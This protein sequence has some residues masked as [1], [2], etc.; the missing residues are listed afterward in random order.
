MNDL[1][2]GTVTLLFAD[3]EGSTRLLQNLGEHYANLLADF[4]HLLRTAFAQHNG[5]E[6][7]TG[8]D[9]FFVAF[10]RASDAVAAAVDIQRTLANHSWPEG[11][12]VRVRI[13][14][15]TGEPQLSSEDYI[16]LE[17][18]HT[19]RIMSAGHGGQILLS[20]TT[21]E[22]VEQHLPV[23]TYLRDM[24]EHRLK[25]L[26]RPSHLFQLSITG[27]PEDFPPLK[28][29]D[30][31][32]NNLPIEPTTFI[33]RQKEIRALCDLLRRPDIRLLALTGPGGVGK[34]RLALRVAA[35][36]TELFRDGVFVV[37]LAPVYDPGQVVPAIAQ[38]LS[39][40]EA[41]DQPLF[42]LV[43]NVLREKRLLLLLDNFE[44][45]VDAAPQI[46]ELLSACPELK[47]LVTSRV[48]LH[49]Q[50]EREFA[51][52]PLPVP[53]PKRLPDPAALSQYEA[54]ALFIERATAVKPG[55]QVTNTNAPA[56]AAICARLDGLPLAIE[57]AAARIRH[58]SP[59]AL[60]ARLEQ[61]LAVL[62]GGA[63]DL[64]GR[65]QTL[66][67]AIAWSYELLS[68]DEQ[69]LFRRLSIFVDGCSWEATEEVC[70]AAGALEGD[71]LEGLVSLVDKSLLRLEE[72]TEGEARFWMLQ[73]LR[74]FGLECLADAG[75]WEVTRSAHALFYLRLAEEAE[76]H[77]R[78]PDAGRWFARLE[79]EHENLRAALSFLLEQAETGAGGEKNRW[80]EQVMRLCG[81][82]YWFWTIHGYYREGRSF[83]ERA[84]AVREGVAAPA[85]IK[86]L[87]AA[88][89]LAITQDDFKRAE[90]LC[91]ESL[92]LSQ[93]MGDSAH[94]ATA[95][96]QLGF[97]SLWR[98]QYAEA[99][100]HMEEAVSLFR[101]L[102]DTWN[103]ARALAYLA[104]V[105]AAQG[106]YSRA[107]LLGEES[108][109]LSRALGNKGRIAI[110]LSELARMSFLS[111]DDPDQAQ[112]LAEESLALFRELGDT[113]YIAVLY[114]LLGE[115]H[116]VQGQ[117]AEARELL[118]ES[119]ATFKE[120]GDRWS[121]AEALLS[122]ARIA[123]SLG[124]I[125]TAAASF[126]ESLAIAQEIDVKAL[127][128]SALEGIG[129]LAT[130]QGEPEWAARIWGTARALRAAIG[131]PL[132]PVYRASYEQALAAS[133][134]LL[135]EESFAATLAEGE[136][137]PLEQA[138]DALL[139]LFS[140]LSNGI[141]APW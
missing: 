123:A 124:E 66:R 141:P 6:I 102:G 31:A 44:Q 138:L 55:F 96:F 126:Q 2:T 29:L 17:V 105:L 103:T 64:P 48:R 125:A 122:F 99:R 137:M 47:I 101:K 67:A 42:A 139:P 18:H 90:A 30:A 56:V 111:Q 65:Q 128:A 108:L 25:D 86:V 117:Q 95:L 110:A 83:L 112:A 81:A 46:A 21:S 24:G 52:L 12:S 140:R 7:S 97:I 127:I 130:A 33:G 27:L 37:A 34:T 71:I 75:E 77:L 4:R 107:R 1:P 109:K 69:K 116:L 134:T 23:G 10:A 72:R 85:Q 35:E 16:G 129:A 51:V 58:F 14:L 45:V 32:P 68:P 79:Q 98:C 62:S 39:I 61:G 73:V 114:S 74:E 19:A 131:S 49:V 40:G 22:L 136:S 133:R 36:L 88:T 11:V 94:K 135:G 80:A 76:P 41:G 38:T 43:K 87:F 15:H 115:M 60:L 121:T 113:Q 93:E 132:P 57:L 84:L 78:G 118:E 3:I 8:G 50:A 70:M 9:S 92:A 53:N 104:R 82:L 26:Q 63:R 106:E 13:G 54:V 119:V 89:E 100:R 28:T 5:H 120:L 59:Q 20:R 91:K